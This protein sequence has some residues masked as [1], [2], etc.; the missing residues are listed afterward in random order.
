MRELEVGV[1]D[2]TTLP[3]PASVAAVSALTAIQQAFA[4]SRIG[5]QLRLLDMK[6]V[7]EVQSLY[8]L[9]ERSKNGG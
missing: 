4:I 3:N 9:K 8:E 2:I 6:A 5:G 1:A 7:Q